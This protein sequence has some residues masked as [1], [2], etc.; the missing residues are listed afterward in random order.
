M[1]RP[2]SPA[3]RYVTAGACL[4]IVVLAGCGYGGPFGGPQSTTPS[5]ESPSQTPQMTPSDETPPTRSLPE[6]TPTSVAV[7]APNLTVTGGDPSVDAGRVWALTMRV[8]TATVSTYPSVTIEESMP[9]ILPDPPPF[10]RLLGLNGGESAVEAAAYVQDPETVH[11]NERIVDRPVLFEYTLA[12][13]Y[14]HVVQFR[15]GVFDQMTD[16]YGESPDERATSMAVTEGTAV[17]AADIYWHRHIARGPSPAG[18]VA[19][20]RRNATG[21][22]WYATAPYYF[23]YRYAADRLDSPATLQRIYDDPP[24]TTEELL[25]RLRPGSEPPATLRLRVDDGGNDENEWDE[26][27]DARNRL[28]ELYVR[29]ALRTELDGDHAA[30]GADGWGE[31]TRLAFEHEN[32]DEDGYIWVLRWDDRANTSE[33]ADAFRAYLDTRATRRQGTWMNGSTAYRIERVGDRTTVVFVGPSTFV[34][35]ATA[36]TGENGTITVRPP[37]RIA[38]RPGLKA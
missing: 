15:W 23:G 37:N 33:F 32:R 34:E 16:H 19:R 25:H 21:Y 4:L 30:R 18:D 2:E 35:N 26:V 5:A 8:L 9:A 11:V 38:A 22:T 36:R 13:E 31:D 10:A 20:I 3:L 17:Y 1:P 27:D 6:R 14:V 28:G 24:R 12:H 29:A 7:D